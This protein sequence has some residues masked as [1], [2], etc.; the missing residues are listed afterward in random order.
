VPEGG[1][2]MINLRRHLRLAPLR[3][4]L[5]R[6]LVVASAGAAAYR[7]GRRMPV[8]RPRGP[9]PHRSSSVVVELEHLARLRDRGAISD[10]E[11]DTAKAEVLD[12]A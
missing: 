8:P 11:F 4:L 1:E 6:G 3:R 12:V 7:F 5:L 9:L 10:A 2:I